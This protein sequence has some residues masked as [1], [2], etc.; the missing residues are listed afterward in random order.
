MEATVPRVVVRRPQK[1]SDEDLAT[2][3]QR[4]DV[5]A[6]EELVRRY[7]RLVYRILWSR[8]GGTAEDV[9][10][11]AQDTFVKVWERLSTYDA[12]LPFKPWIARVAGNLAID[13]H[14]AR[15][16]RP[17][18]VELAPG[19]TESQAV[20]DHRADPAEAVTGSE[21]QRAL[22]THL[23]HLPPHYREVLVLRFVEDLSYEQIAEVLGIPLGSVKTRI[24]R[25]REL[26]KQRL[27]VDCVEG[28]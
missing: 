16:R 26:L 1:H 11:M 24:F 21:E 20:S 2:R 12:R 19:Q 17:V 9:E 22:L 3:A 13:R 7:Q 14:R 15:A 5:A 4:G 25:S 10:D 27:A 6:Y 18:T 23:R 28:V 8:G